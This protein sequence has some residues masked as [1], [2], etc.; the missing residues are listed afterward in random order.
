[1][2]DVL[3]RFLRYVQ[4]DTQSADEHSDVLNRFLR[5]VQVDT[6]SADEHCDQVPSTA[7]QF[8]LANMLAD[9]LRDLGARDVTVSENAYVT[10][11]IP[12]SEGAEDRPRLGLISHLDTTEQ[13]PGFGV[14]PR[15]P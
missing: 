4:V 15:C 8:D 6:Q 13:A 3:N 7:I 11:W 2:S 14:K 5:Y 10:A 9:E 12:A 1:M